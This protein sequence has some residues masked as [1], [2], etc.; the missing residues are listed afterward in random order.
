M[1]ERPNRRDPLVSATIFLEGA[2]K[3]PDSKEQQIRCR[4]AFHKLL[5]ACDFKKRMPRLKS[6]GPRGAAFDDFKIAVA[7]KTSGDY[8]ALWIDSEDPVKDLE[9]T[10]E[11]LKL[12]DRWT[13]PAGALDND[14]LF[15]TTCMETL[16]VADHAALKKH[17]G[18]KLQTSALPSLT[19]LESQSRQGIQK[20]L[21]HA[22]RNCTNSYTKGD[23]SFKILAELQPS[24]LASHL[25]S[26]VRTMRILDESLPERGFHQ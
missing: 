10:W 1:D 20:K 23:R 26:F 6:C 8:V 25:P 9:A 17:Y 21:E 22:T 7:R 24:T 19:N 15:M 16:I 14:V 2:A 18:A 12:R 4:E 5:E 3:G 11:H 13:Q